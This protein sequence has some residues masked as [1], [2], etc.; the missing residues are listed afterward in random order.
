MDT[1]LETP[2]A[3]A[4]T[5]LHELR[6]MNEA[7]YIKETHF[8]LNKYLAG[9]NP[10]IVELRCEAS[11][12]RKIAPKFKPVL[13]RTL[14]EFP[15]SE[16]DAPGI[17]RAIADLRQCCRGH[18]GTLE[19]NPPAIDRLIAH[20]SSYR[21]EYFISYSVATMLD[22]DRRTAAC[23]LHRSKSFESLLGEIE[24][25]KAGIKE[26][27]SFAAKRGIFTPALPGGRT[28]KPKEN[29]DFG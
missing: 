10:I 25:L 9:A 24:K 5:T 17:K 29:I 6:Q 16:F 8:K 28:L 4:S 27:I 23:L 19:E 15:A 11:A 21:P 12:L 18:L 14:A 3:D 2:A 26:A 7:S 1:K 20:M 22:V 13:E